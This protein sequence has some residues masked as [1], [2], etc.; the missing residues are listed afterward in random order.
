MA[1]LPDTKT[2]APLAT[3]KAA[4][5][6]GIVLLIALISLD[7]AKGVSVPF[8]PEQFQVTHR[9]FNSEFTENGCLED[10]IILTFRA[11]V[12]FQG[13]TAKLRGCT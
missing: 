3:G 1:L 10:D 13:R 7:Q 12:T 11:S 4:V 9:K 8:V 5:S 6:C 2:P